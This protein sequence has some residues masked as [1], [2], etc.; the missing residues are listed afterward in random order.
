MYDA[1]VNSEYLLSGNESQDWLVYDAI[2]NSE[3]LLS[4]NESQE[5]KILRRDPEGR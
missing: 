3:H 5:L 1:I 4:G 2:M